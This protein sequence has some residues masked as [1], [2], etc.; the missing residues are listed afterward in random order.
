[1]NVW[2]CILWLLFQPVLFWESIFMLLSPFFFPPTVTFL[3]L[4]ACLM[5]I[6]RS[7]VKLHVPLQDQKGDSSGFSLQTDCEWRGGMCPRPHGP[8]ARGHFAHPFSFI[9][10][11]ILPWPRKFDFVSCSVWTPVSFLVCWV[12]LCVPWTDDGILPEMSEDMDLAVVSTD[13]K[14]VASQIL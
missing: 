4:S 7:H 14:R 10:P 8:A 1:M 6:D 3:N 2:I 11:Y 12:S 9:S 5:F 13:N